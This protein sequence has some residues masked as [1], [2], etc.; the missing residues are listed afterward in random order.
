MF[1]GPAL[2]EYLRLVAEIRG[3]CKRNSKRVEE[4]EE[5]AE[6]VVKEVTVLPNIERR[7]R[8]GS[9]AT[10]KI[11]LTCET[12]ARCEAQMSHNAEQSQQLLVEPKRTGGRLRSPA[13]SPIPSPVTS[14]SPTRSRFQVCRVAESD[15]PIT[16]PS[17]SPNVFFGGS[18]RFKVTVVETSDTSIPT[19]VVTP[20]NITVGFETPTCLSPNIAISP[21]P[22]PTPIPAPLLSSISSLF[23]TPMLSPLPSPGV[24]P[25]PSPTYIP[26]MSS[27]SVDETVPLFPLPGRCDEK[28]RDEPVV[29]VVSDIGRETL[30]NNCTELSVSDINRSVNTIS[31][32]NDNSVLKD[33]VDS[34]VSFVPGSIFEP[35]SA[36]SKDNYSFNS[37]DSVSP[38][39]PYNVRSES[40]ESDKDALLNRKLP[41][42]IDSIDLSASRVIKQASVSVSDK[43]PT[44]SQRERKKSSW[45]Q[46]STMF[47]SIMQ[48]D[49][50]KPSSSLERL[51][52]LFV[53][54][55]TRSKVEDEPTQQLERVPEI[56]ESSTLRN[57]SETTDVSD[58]SKTSIDITTKMQ[59]SITSVSYVEQHNKICTSDNNIKDNL[60]NKKNKSD[61]QLDDKSSYTTRNGDEPK[62]D[63]QK[64][65]IPF[66][67]YNNDESVFEATKCKT[68]PQGSSES[69]LNLA[70]PCY[71][72]SHS[73]P[74]L[75][76]LVF[77][78]STGK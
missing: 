39:K 50:G 12:L 66:L 7:P 41:K 49:S 65:N 6:E 18:S 63:E 2:E 56:A 42:A 17:Y 51:L 75:A 77:H 64:V 13:P 76:A 25:Y 73:S 36:I 24:S 68:W 22:S 69:Q 40:E 15:S 62:C 44:P 61:L 23:P 8:A 48:D 1:K 14:P 28:V 43:A 60:T 10:R 70:Q 16:P 45:T 5:V 19:T 67:F 78:L 20:N 26:P 33:N 31:K 37:R 35:L 71:G 74:C 38:T 57:E 52:G 27:V 32:N 58:L 29:P 4:I 21:A 46:P 9:F 3:Y 59:Q 11:S 55:F 34:Y 53:N 30:L 47:S 54:P 72:Q